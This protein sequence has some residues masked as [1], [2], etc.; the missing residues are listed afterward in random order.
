MVAGGHR[1][2]PV[3]DSGGQSSVWML[4]TKA[5]EWTWLRGL[6]DRNYNPRASIVGGRLRLTGGWESGIAK[7]EVMSECM[8]PSKHLTSH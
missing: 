6:P 1:Y 5:K 3:G 2:G 4:V 7:T 8:L